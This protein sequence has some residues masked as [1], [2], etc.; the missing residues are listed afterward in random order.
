[1]TRSLEFPQR[2][3][4]VSVEISRPADL[5]HL[6]VDL[7]VVIDVLRMT[8]T[9]SVLMRSF[10]SLSVVATLQ[11][12]ERLP[13]PLTDYAVISEL[14]G[15]QRAGSWVDNSP[16]QVLR[17]D[18]AQRV[19]VLVTTN[20]TRTLFAATGCAERVLLACFRDI[21][22]VAQYIASTESKSVVLVPAGDFATGQ[23]RIEDDLCAEALQL[24]LA[25]RAPDL[26]ALTDIMRRDPNI[27]RRLATESGFEADFTLAL[28][29][30]AE[31]SLLEFVPLTSGVG[32][33]VRA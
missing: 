14:R 18:W 20:G 15:A 25:G 4:G 23:P 22:S 11:D 27:G 2:T 19:P 6:R 31:A 1:M 29:S 28:Q 10:A 3:V 5:S 30:D 32:R 17:M 21:Q 33:I 26:A 7:A 12:L 24:L 13:R 16:A 9:A 8:S